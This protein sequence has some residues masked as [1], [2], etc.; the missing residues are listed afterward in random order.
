MIP[1]AGN[2]F[3]ADLA[4]GVQTECQLRGFFV[5]LS[6]THNQP[7]M[8]LSDLQLV[9]IDRSIGDP[10]VISIR[11]DHEMGGYLATKHLL[12]LGHR[13]VGVHH[14]PAGGGLGLAAVCRVQARP[15]GGGRT[16]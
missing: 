13:R 9:L 5:L 7:E 15:A 14:R 6:C 1:D 11:V 8:D 2:T 4:K 3:L 10:A 16:L 12:E